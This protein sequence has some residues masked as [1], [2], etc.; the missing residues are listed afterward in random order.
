MTELAEKSFRNVQCFHCLLH[1]M[2]GVVAAADSQIRRDFQS[3]ASRTCLH[4]FPRLG[5]NALPLVSQTTY[6][7]SNLLAMA[8]VGFLEITR[9][10]GRLRRDLPGVGSWQASSVRAKSRFCRELRPARCGKLI[11][12]ALAFAI[13]VIG[14]TV[15]RIR[16]LPRAQQSYMV[17]ANDRQLLAGCCRSPEK[18]TWLLNDCFQGQGRTGSD[19]VRLIRFR[20]LQFWGLV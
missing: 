2:V 4:S 9:L 15:R 3:D 17:V 1:S 16:P 18:C 20:L 8:T 19:T 7:R 14:W 12:E 6:N 13:T 5:F 11:A 10:A